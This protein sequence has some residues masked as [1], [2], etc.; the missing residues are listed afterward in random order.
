V[1]PGWQRAL[2]DSI[3]FPGTTIGNG[4]IVLRAIYGQARIAQSPRRY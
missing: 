3:V 1:V 2:R 4:Q